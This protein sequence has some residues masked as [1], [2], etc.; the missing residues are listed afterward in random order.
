M[1]E[2]NDKKKL[3]DVKLPL[4]NSNRKNN[5]KSI[6]TAT[7]KNKDTS[8]LSILSQNSLK[9]NSVKSSNLDKKPQNKEDIKSN[10]F[11]SAMN[12][13][14]L[15][16][17]TN[18]NI[19][20]SKSKTNNKTDDK[21]NEII[22]DVNN[23]RNIKAKVNSNNINNMNSF[24]SSETSNLKEKELNKIQKKLTNKKKKYKFKIYKPLN[25]L[26]APHEDMSFLKDNSSKEKFFNDIKNE[27][28]RITKGKFDKI[29]K[30]RIERLEKEKKQIEYS[31]RQIMNDIKGQNSIIKSR[32][33]VLNGIL[34]SIKDSRNKISQKNAQKILEEGGMIE[35]YK[36]LIKNLCKN[37]MPEGNVY[38]YCSDFIK[39]FERVW[40]KIKFRM[41]NKEIEEHFKKEKESLIK[42][43]ENN[44][45]NIFYKALEQREEIRFI[46]KLDKSRS[47]LRII[48]RY[49]I[50]GN[51]INKNNMIITNIGNNKKSS[52]NNNISNKKEGNKSINLINEI[53]SIKTLE[54]K[55]TNKTSLSEQ[56]LEN[57]QLN[58][59]LSK[60]NSLA[61][62]KVTFNIKLKKNEDEEKQSEEMKLNQEKEKKKVKEKS[63]E[64]SKENSK[65]KSKEKSKEIKKENEKV[66]NE[67]NSKNP[68]IIN[69]KNNEIKDKEIQKDKKKPA[70]KKDKKGKIKIDD[71]SGK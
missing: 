1:N 28:L 62:N 14:I 63:K 69:S 5:I 22:N 25:P 19:N 65:E 52:V 67:I 39:N 15:R 71:K 17:N 43:N 16:P 42:K 31:N 6:K 47:S 33:I 41:L 10:T 37:G 18:T 53:K 50:Q 70:I 38:D 12:K 51:E 54:R 35:A 24:N 11:N 8:S 2:K 64:K 32:E 34:N 36:Y 48:K 46:K 9:A 61:S 3:K 23:S 58:N 68:T 55:N 13:S 29:K 44:R 4:I 27:P 20:K 66:E 45:S 60:K 57:I 21:I 7:N 26:L 56:N 49:Q 40:Q 30:R 59:L